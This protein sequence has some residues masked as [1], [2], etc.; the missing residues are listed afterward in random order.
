MNRLSEA[1]SHRS[2]A[3]KHS[4]LSALMGRGMSMSFAEHLTE[5]VLQLGL[6]A[7]RKCYNP[8]LQSTLVNRPYLVGDNLAFASVYLAGNTERIAMDCRCDRNNDDRSKIPVEF[9]RAYTTQGR[10]FCI[11]A[12]TVGLR[13][14]Q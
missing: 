5:H 1:K 12:P 8:L 4:S 10:I 9:I 6:F 11:S 14:T 3:Q 13:S 7:R 2:D